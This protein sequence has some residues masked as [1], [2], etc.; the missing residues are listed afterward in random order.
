MFPPASARM[1]AIFVPPR[2]I[3]IY[4]APNPISLLL[5]EYK[6]PPSGMGD[7]NKLTVRLLRNGFLCFLIKKFYFR[8]INNQTVF[9]TVCSFGMSIDSGGETMGFLG[10]MKVNLGTD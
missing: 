5:S 1:P 6:N 2:S 3:P 8:I 10:D 9:R 4:L 7:L